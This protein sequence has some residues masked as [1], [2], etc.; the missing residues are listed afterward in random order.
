VSLLTIATSTAL[1]C[2]FQLQ[3]KTQSWVF[4]KQRSN[5]RLHHEGK[6][7]QITPARIQKLENLGFEWKRSPATGRGCQ[8]QSLDDDA[9]RLR[10][11]VVEAPEHTPQH[12]LKTT[13]V[14]QESQQSI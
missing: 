9:T 2:S 1:Q 14:V 11:R 12:S 4:K 13:S 5:Y 3:Q 8:K 7:S 6:K 10:E